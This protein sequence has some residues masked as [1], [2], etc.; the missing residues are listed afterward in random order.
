[1]K[2]EAI[3]IAA[4]IVACA[5][6]HS[7]AATASSDGYDP[8]ADAPVYAIAL[9]PDGKALIGG[10]FTAVGGGAFS[11]IARINADG[12][13]DTVFAAQADGRVVA[14][15]VQPDS[16]ILISGQFNTVN[17][18]M[19]NCIARLN[20]DGT[21]DDTFLA[22]GANGFVNAMALE[23]G[24]RIVIG[25]D[26]T[27]VNGAACNRIA[28]L[29]PN[30]QVDTDFQSVPGADRNIFAI[31]LQRDG[32]ILIAG[33]YTEL[34]GTPH[35]QIARLNA[36][37]S[38][39]P[40]FIPG[41]AAGS[42]VTAVKLQVDGKIL[43]GGCFGGSRQQV[44]RLNPDGSIDAMFGAADADDAIGALAT[45]PDGRIVMAGA[46]RTVGGASRN[47]IARLNLDGSIDPA[48]A[49]PRTSDTIRAIAVQSDTKILIAG[50]FTRVQ[51]H[52]RNH[53]AKLYADASIDK[54]FAPYFAGK[55]DQFSVYAAGL[56]MEGNIYFGG[57]NLGY[58]GKLRI[59]H[60]DGSAAQAFQFNNDAQVYAVSPQADG[61]L[62]IGGQFTR[63]SETTHFA[64]ARLNFNGSVDSS[65][66]TTLLVG[67]AVNAL[68]IQPDGK[69]LIGGSLCYIPRFNS[70]GSLDVN[71]KPGSGTD[72]PI[73]SIALQTDGKILVG[74]DFSRFNNLSCPYILRLNA[75]GSI[76]A[77]FKTSSGPNNGVYA[78]IIQS[79]G[80]VLIGGSFDQYNGVSRNH[81]ARLNADG[82]L[83]VSFD[84]GPITEGGVRSMTLQADGKLIIVGTFKDFGHSGRNGIARLNTNGSVDSSFKSF[85][86]EADSLAVQSDGKLLVSSL[87]LANPDAACQSL[88]ISNDGYT[89]IWNLGGSYP[90]PYQVLF[91]T[92][93]D[94]IAWKILGWGFP[95]PSFG[96][97]LNNLSKPIQQNHYVRATG[98][99]AGGVFNGSVSLH[100]S[101]LWAGQTGL[102]ISAAHDWALYR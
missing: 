92:S 47:R 41:I 31:E 81:V 59:V 14:I 52:P 60:K 39:D 12:T 89:V 90:W 61:K 77:S 10:D 20:A 69:I 86:Y 85:N 93:T 94:G 70:D 50:D 91:E 29:M 84:P 8:N 49:D 1:M 6:S 58:L 78:I 18:A 16:K 57:T 13:T 15:A 83:D 2:I 9:Q 17:G 25:G 46:F 38:V 64:I 51:D 63:I 88:S 82:S 7:F 45:Q 42:T 26:F 74:G 54:N 36:N 73:L 53:I 67:D 30:G 35:S 101:V 80:K 40:N 4:L 28:R 24:G 37:G 22:T 55:E 97:R 43:L 62:L 76:D 44:V 100:R 79:D 32:K 66:N 5:V 71:F 98:W 34:D 65:F 48:F 56:D 72:R 96:Y 19:H 87:R 23:P 27:R 102:P 11:R 21:I 68:I 99:V 3:L 95:V 33:E 75:N